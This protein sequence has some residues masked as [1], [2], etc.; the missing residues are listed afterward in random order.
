MINALPKLAAGRG[1]RALTCSAVV[2]SAA[3]T[4]AAAPP[5][6]L[7]TFARNGTSTLNAANQLVLTPALSFQDG[8]AFRATPIATAG[9]ASFVAR[10]NY[11]IGGGSGA[12]GLAFVLQGVGPTALGGA[13]ANVGFVGIDHSVGALL[14]T[15]S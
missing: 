12:D 2:A 10:F 3:A 6:D 13:G 8:S 1:L 4:P 11:A 15:F 5:Q 14:R 7:A 9:L